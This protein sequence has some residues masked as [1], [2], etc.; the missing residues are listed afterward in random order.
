MEMAKIRK[1]DRDYQGW[2]DGVQLGQIGSQGQLTYT[3]SQTSAANYYNA[4]KIS[5]AGDFAR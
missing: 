3:S 2:D 5:S 1:R 4:G